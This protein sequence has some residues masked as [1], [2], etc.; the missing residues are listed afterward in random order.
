MDPSSLLTGGGVPSV[1]GGDAQSDSFSD[2]FGRFDS[3]GLISPWYFGGSG[4]GLTGGIAVLA[5]VLVLWK[6]LKK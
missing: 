1:T 5:L 6:I 4:G 3:G 2:N